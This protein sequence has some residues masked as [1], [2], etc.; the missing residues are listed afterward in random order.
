MAI[1]GGECSPH[2]TLKYGNSMNILDHVRPGYCFYKGLL[3]INKTS[4]IVVKKDDTVCSLLVNV[5]PLAWG[6]AFVAQLNG[7]N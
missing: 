6:H 7:F 5:K 3:T 1:L 2:K 4:F